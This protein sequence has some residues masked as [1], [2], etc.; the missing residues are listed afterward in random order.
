M[1]DGWSYGSVPL[2]Y[3][4]TAVGWGTPVVVLTLFGI[5]STQMAL[6]LGIGGAMVLP[7]VTFKFT[8]RLW[9]GIYYALIPQELRPRDPNERGD[10]H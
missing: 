10:V 1:E 4:L 9:I 8:K 6:I 7:I 5:L 3:I 2:A